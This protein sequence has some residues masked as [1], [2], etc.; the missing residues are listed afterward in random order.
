[1]VAKALTDAAAFAGESL[2]QT[3]GN[4]APSDSILR[5]LVNEIALRGQS[6]S[7]AESLTGGM[8]AAR[9]VSVPGVSEIFRGGIVSYTNEIKERILGVDS[10]L[11]AEGGPVQGNV[12]LQMATG[13][14]KLFGTDYALATTGVAGPGPAD[15]K[16]QGTVYIAV[17][18][19]LNVRYEEFHFDG[20]RLSVRE[21]SVQEA[22]AALRE[23]VF[24]VSQSAK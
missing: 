24:A 17:K 9:V 20:D 10:C 1:M 19:P 11:L 16:P 7:V 4:R 3:S 12:A 14:A 2:V 23:D 22:L 21:Q 13:V 5:A 15:G 18:T 8:L 6:L